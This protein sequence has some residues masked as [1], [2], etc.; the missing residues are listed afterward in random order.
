MLN[1]N[2]SGSQT[3]LLG[4]SADVS[5]CLNIVLF[6]QSKLSTKIS[7]YGM[8]NFYNEVILKGDYLSLSRQSSEN[9]FEYNFRNGIL[10]GFDLIVYL[11]KSNNAPIGFTEF[12]RIQGTSRNLSITLN[13]TSTSDNS[14]SNVT[15]SGSLSQ[16]KVTD[17]SL[18]LLGE[19]DYNY[20]S[21]AKVFENLKTPQPSYTTHV[22]DLD[23]NKAIVTS[24]CG[25]VKDGLYKCGILR[26]KN[27]DPHGI[28]FTGFSFCKCDTDFVIL[29]W[30]DNKYSIYSM[31]TAN[32]FG[33]PKS[34]TGVYNK[35]ESSYS[36]DIYSTNYSGTNTAILKKASGFCVIKKYDENKDQKIISCTGRYILVDVEGD[37]KIYD[38]LKKDKDGEYGDWI[39]VNAPVVIDERSFIPGLVILE[40][41][42]ENFILG[43]PELTNLYIDP[44]PLF[45][46]NLTIYRRIGSWFVLQY[47]YSVDTDM[48]VCASPVSS[49]YVT[50]DDLD[51]LIF[52]NDNT[53]I[54]KEDK[55]YTVYSG[56]K[57]T[58]Y[59]ER[60][61]NVIEG[62][63][64]EP[65]KVRGVEININ[66]NG[67]SDDLYKDY[68]RDRDI[69]I[70]GKSE[71]LYTTIF[72]K[73]RK[74]SYPLDIEG[75]PDIIGGCEGL[76][77][78]KNGKIINYL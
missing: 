59:S 30:T 57:K 48:Y 3:Q 54:I 63:T 77:F 15:D 75:I 49:I 62:G 61:R 53:L 22:E 13:I 10:E 69:E 37:S 20:T 40:S 60:A 26:N 17:L 1:P 51:K 36:G 31:T 28:G 45:I 66:T 50:K 56:Y 38:V 68:Y 64:L 29:E 72:N 65:Y 34:Y 41:G 35:S 19:E 4:S 55:Y 23:R 9:S 24:S 39:E 21:G 46:K 25:V 43:C 47:D 52:L 2:T 70:V 74:N 44:A 8:K 16:L 58:L 78:Y 14:D 6:N 27:F 11:Q 33:N 5:D 73:Y 7:L 12:S 76:L 18:I 32:A 71:E 42:F 67:T